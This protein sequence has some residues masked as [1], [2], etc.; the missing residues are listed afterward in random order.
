M[1]KLACP[2]FL[3]LPV[4]AQSPFRTTRHA[5]LPLIQIGDKFASGDLDGD[6][7]VDLF[8][9]NDNSPNQVLRNDGSGR[10]TDV[11]AISIVQ[12]S[13]NAT[14][15]VNLADID[16]DG[17]LDILIGNDDFL[18]NRV[19]RNNGAGVFTDVTATALPPNAHFT[20][21]QVV[22]DFDGDGDV[23]WFTVD[24]GPCHFYENDGTG[25]F[26]DAT[27]AR[28]AGLPL[29]NGDR[30][31]VTPFAADIDGDGDLDVMVP[32]LFSTP[33][34]I[35]NQSGVLVP[36]PSQLTLAVSNQGNWFADVDGDGDPDVFASGGRYLLQNQGN[37]TFVDV[38]ATAFG[39]AP[40][41][42]LASFDIDNDGDVDLVTTTSIW[43]NN[44][45]GVFTAQTV[46]TTQPYGF[47]AG[48]A[49]ADFD[50]DG[51]VDLPG[52]P[53]FLHQVFAATAPVRGASYLL[54]C[55]GRP[56]TTSLIVAC[57]ATGPGIVPVPG[58]GLLRL[59]PLSAQV[60]G[61]GT[62]NSTLSLTW[63]VPNL[64]ALAGAEVH[65]QSCVIDPIEGN[66]IANVIRDVVQ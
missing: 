58:F 39:T 38:T 31:D 16:G 35:R 36:N 26:S 5:G 8:V 62:V 32:R 14:H 59:D 15:S 22:A 56:G 9:A 51:D 60:C 53:N 44:G 45:L 19:Y 20:E 2:L 34:L 46:S 30:W 11:T 1:L 18:S 64:P 40:L 49:A 61:F 57:C 50:G 17:D 3:L 37:G 54:E 28:V 4:V 21:C 27:A 7:D 6:G 47:N 12:P 48:Y 55:H 29:I 23:D 10:F 65:F 13:T 24:S 33:Y 41:G 63:N 43:T 25:V 52:R 66:V 42:A